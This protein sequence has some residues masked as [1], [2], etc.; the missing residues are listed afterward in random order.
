MLAGVV[1]WV[2][3]LEAGVG[4]EPTNN[5]FAGDGLTSWLSRRYLVTA[6]FCRPLPYDAKSPYSS[7]NVPSP[8]RSLPDF[9]R[10]KYRMSNAVRTEATVTQTIPSTCCCSSV[11]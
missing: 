1:P 8:E 9:C 11:W 10:V 4:I 3:K 2:E 6:T 7:Q 5:R